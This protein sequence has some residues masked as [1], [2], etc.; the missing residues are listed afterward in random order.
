MNIPENIDDAA[1]ATAVAVD[2]STATSKHKKI[3]IFMNMAYH[4]L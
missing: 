3:G 4:F 2:A 1:A